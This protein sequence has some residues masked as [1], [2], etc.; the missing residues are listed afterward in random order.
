MEEIIQIS[1]D[2]AHT[3]EASD[4]Q[5]DLLLKTIEMYDIVLGLFV[6]RSKLGTQFEASKY[7]SKTRSSVSAPQACFHRTFI[8]LVAP[9][10]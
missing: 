6:H 7:R 10:A 2:V 4:P 9:G 5:D 1:I 8:C 3:H